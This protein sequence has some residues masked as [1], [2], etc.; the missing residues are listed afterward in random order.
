MVSMADSDATRQA[1][2]RRHAAGDHSLC[3]KRCQAAR[4]RAGIGE[5]PAG[6]AEDLDP[7]AA[8]A[9]L[10]HGLMDEWKA[11]RRNSVLAREL[12]QTLLVLVPRS[13]DG[14]QA[15][16]NE[17]IRELS[18]PVDTDDRYDGR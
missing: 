3:T 2:R 16:W 8:L 7:K 13:D 6:S 4:T 17:L 5:V 9:E 11:D 18:T 12:R 1:R 14:M 10:A 15:A